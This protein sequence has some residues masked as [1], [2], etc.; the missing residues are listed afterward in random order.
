MNSIKCLLALQMMVNGTKW[1]NSFCSI[2]RIS[3]SVCEWANK[4]MGELT[5][6]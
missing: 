4:Q 6:L 1:I 3:G 2:R 5:N